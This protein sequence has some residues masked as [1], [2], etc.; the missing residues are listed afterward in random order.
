MLC[1][2][3][4]HTIALQMTSAKEEP[5]L[6]LHSLD[7]THRASAAS[8]A[9]L[10][11][12]PV[13]LIVHALATLRCPTA[14]LSAGSA[15]KLLSALTAEPIC[16]RSLVL[17]PDVCERLCAISRVRFLNLEE[18]RVSAERTTHSG[19]FC[20]KGA[21]VSGCGFLSQCGTLTDAGALLRRQHASIRLVNER[22]AQTMRVPGTSTPRTST[23]STSTEVESRCPLKP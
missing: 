1:A 23:R 14:L 4:E 20:K 3:N 15:C 2:G 9:A 12:L 10:L 19:K 16:W 13:E 5:P 8:A 6:P 22:P 7:G 11:S 17:Q 18:I 21:A